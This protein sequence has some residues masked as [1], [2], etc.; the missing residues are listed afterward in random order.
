MFRWLRML[1]V[2]V[3]VDFYLLFFCF[4]R[5]QRSSF[6]YLSLLYFWCSFCCRN[7]T[8]YYFDM[9][10][11]RNKKTTNFLEQR[12]RIHFSCVE[13]EIHSFLSCGF[14]CFGFSR[15]RVETRLSTQPFVHSF[16]FLYFCCCVYYV[17]LFF[18]LL[19]FFSGFN[20][21]FRTVNII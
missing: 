19:F 4:S 9:K 3:V 15:L 13:N 21:V 16:F 17:F 7:W 10:W 20:R 2:V 1:T 11:N 18:I 6:P 5:L 12:G 8:W 14:V